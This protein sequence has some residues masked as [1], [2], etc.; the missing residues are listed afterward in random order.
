MSQK[1]KDIPLTYLLL[2]SYI[3]ILAVL[4]LVGTLIYHGSARQVLSGI[5][6]QNRL[7]LSSSVAQMDQNL[8]VINAAARQIT[9]SSTLMTLNEL[10]ETTDDS[11][12]YKG[13]QAQ[14]SLATI[15]PVSRLL[16]ASNCY[17][18]MENSDYIVGSTVFSDFDFYV[19]NELSRKLSSEELKK[20]FADS[21]C[22]NRFIPLSDP[23]VSSYLYVYPLFP[24]V[25][26]YPLSVSAMTEP[27]VKW[28]LICEFDQHT[29][30]ELFSDL[31]FYEGGYLRIF[32]HTGEPVLNLTENGVIPEAIADF[33]DLIRL[34]YENQVASFTSK[35]THQEMLV[36]QVRSSY[37]NW[38][39]FLVQP[40]KQAY[41]STTS[42]MQYFWGLMLA[43]IC[44]G[45][46]IAFTVFATGRKRLASL[47]NALSEKD[48]LNTTLNQQVE[49][50]KPMVLETYMRR[51][52]EGSITTNEEMQ[53]IITTLNL[54]RPGIKYHV[55]CAEVSPAEGRLIPSQDREICLQNY[56]ILAREALKRYFP[57]T[58]YI[59]KPT[60]HSFA[61]L[62]ASE[63]QMP[64]EQVID[65]DRE[66]FIA[67]HN[68][69][70][71]QYGIWIRGGFGGRNGV[72]SYT[73]KSYQ[74]AKETKSVTTQEKYIMSDS[75]FA[76]SSDVYYYPES[77]SVQLSG[78]ISTGNKNQV[79]ELFKL[80]HNENMVK[81]NLPYTQQRWLISDIR[82]TVFKKR[83]NV[84]GENL[85]TEKL[86]L[87][88]VIDKQF[89]GEMSLSILSTIS[90]ELCDIFGSNAE[91][92]D[93]ILKIQEYINN[94]YH[95][96]E[97]GLTKISSEFGI[98]EN[99]FSYLF[100]KEVS[101]NFSTYLERLRMA[102]AKEL[103]LE[104]DTNLSSLYQHVGYNN[105]A[106]FRRAFKRNFDV[107]PKE[108]REKV[109]AK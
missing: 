82:G 69:L 37:N 34:D 79:G 75:D 103:V 66:R 38:T 73:W 5:N 11:F 95:D 62:I 58:G 30:I 80:I 31:N 64:Y 43:A 10:S 16:P 44:S 93:L 56:D 1:R 59:Y 24:A 100:K 33:S 104:S 77:L 54:D 68:E 105:A 32:D 26:A 8:Q 18:Y 90:L 96:P 76:H 99:Y 63:A 88:E 98:S 84:S 39:Y 65:R 35:D 4:L 6:A 57:D 42:Y 91:S 61:V 29:L 2:I 78:F 87:L 41:Y 45:G 12:F 85:N 67:L 52:M 22:W 3:A 17:V 14:K 107:S 21:R 9:Q 20:Q 109:N 106:S 28:S 7:S 47:T 60:D 89:D 23:P 19:R 40:M 102:K 13:Y 48:D 71:K 15:T 36:T 97:L 25:M 72:I 51:I 86:Q 94:N 92:N 70:L 81:R 46:V 55:L 27:Q 53:N 74:Q 101:E 83:L 50:Q 108:M 49:Q